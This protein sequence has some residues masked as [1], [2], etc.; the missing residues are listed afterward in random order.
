[1]SDFITRVAARAVGERGAASARVPSLFEA[2][3]AVGGA[4]LEVIDEEVVAPAPNRGARGAPAASRQTTVARPPSAAPPLQPGESRATRVE[5]YAVPHAEPS[6]EPSHGPLEEIGE[7][8]PD[9]LTTTPAAA[10]PRPRHEERPPA[11]VT[12][13][14]PVLTPAVPILAHAPPRAVSAPAVAAAE[15]PPVRVHIG[16]LEVRANLQEQPRRP[17]RPPVPR[18][19]ELSLSDYLR[20]RRESR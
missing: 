20:G 8:M 3:G 15:P 2:S 13:A 1:M 11:A 4:G 17:E 7:R 16:R 19:Q 18:P 6:A 10:R 5:A 14:A 9:P 12:E